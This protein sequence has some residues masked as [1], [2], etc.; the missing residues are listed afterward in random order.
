[1]SNHCAVLLT[2][3]A[4]GLLRANPRLETTGEYLDVLTEFQIT[5]VRMP[6]TT[7][8]SQDDD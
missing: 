3:G 5:R 4:V 1:M 2:M 7:L 8:F 6:E